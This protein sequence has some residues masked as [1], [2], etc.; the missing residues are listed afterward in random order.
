MSQKLWAHS[1]VFFCIVFSTVS[2]NVIDL[3]PTC[4]FFQL[5]SL[6]FFIRRKYLCFCQMHTFV[7]IF[8]FSNTKFSF[9]ELQFT[10]CFK[11]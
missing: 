9:S 8:L 11:G 6:G 10:I 7:D 3:Y 4:I 2:F 5:L 1:D